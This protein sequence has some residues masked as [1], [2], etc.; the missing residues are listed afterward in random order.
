M[1]VKVSFCLALKHVIEGQVCFDN[2]NKSLEA[3]YVITIATGK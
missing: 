2:I 1:S 3:Y